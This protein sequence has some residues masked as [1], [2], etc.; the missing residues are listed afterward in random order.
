EAAPGPSFAV[1][2]ILPDC[3][4]V[5]SDRPGGIGRLRACKTAI[6]KSFSEGRLERDHAVEIGNRAGRVACAKS[7]HSAVVESAKVFGL[8]PKDTT[9]AGD[10]S[11]EIAFFETNIG[12][13]KHRI[14]VEG[15]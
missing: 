12:S 9:V 6:V 10:G 5:V 14:R 8:F 15:P 7:G 11:R 2:R 3:L 13:R 4:A 1:A